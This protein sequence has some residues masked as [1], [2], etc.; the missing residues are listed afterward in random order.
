L[1]ISTTYNNQKLMELKLAKDIKAAVELDGQAVISLENSIVYESID[2]NGEAF[3]YIKSTIEG[4]ELKIR[5]VKKL[6]EPNTKNNE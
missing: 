1:Q 5:F 2:T 3:I 4:K 6:E